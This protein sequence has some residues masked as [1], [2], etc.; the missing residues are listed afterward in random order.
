MKTF[1]NNL[2]FPFYLVCCNVVAVILWTQ[3]ISNTVSAHLRWLKVSKMDDIHTLIYELESR[4]YT[5]SSLTMYSLLLR[6][7]VNTTLL[8]GLAWY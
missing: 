6:N 7:S 8:F 4:C 1:F 5:Y 2:C 3:T